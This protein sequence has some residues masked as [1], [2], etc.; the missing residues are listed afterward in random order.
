VVVVR[1]PLAQA[2]DPLMD[3]R[4]ERVRSVGWDRYYLPEAM[5]ELK[6]AAGRLIRSS[7][8]TGCLVLAD[9][10]LSTDVPYARRFL[11]ALPVSDVE[12]VPAERL[13]ETIAAR[14][15]RGR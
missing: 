4:K 8:D 10:R 12:R 14:F 9:S 2:S 5:L 7:T 15:A 11:A 6:Q 1:L 3:A 13:R